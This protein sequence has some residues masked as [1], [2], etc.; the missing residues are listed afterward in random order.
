MTRR[1]TTPRTHPVTV[2]AFDGLQLL[3]LAGP[4]E[5]LD[6]ANRIAGHRLYDVQVATPGGGLLHQCRRLRLRAAA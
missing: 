5:V 2:V 1:P 3:D 4:V 6:A